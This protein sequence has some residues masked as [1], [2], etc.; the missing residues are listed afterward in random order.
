[1]RPAQQWLVWTNPAPVCLY[2]LLLYAVYL[3]SLSISLVVNRVLQNKYTKAR[4][5]SPVVNQKESDAI[6]KI[7]REMKG[8]YLSMTE[9]GAHLGCCA[10]GAEGVAAAHGGCLGRA[11]RVRVLQQAAHL[12]RAH[13]RT[14]PAQPSTSVS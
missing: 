11:G 6:K 4:L 5:E 9:A 14:R 2:S 10:H 13:A 8:E 3:S 1:M 12:G 7:Y